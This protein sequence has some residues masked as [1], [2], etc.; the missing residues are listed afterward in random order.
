MVLNCQEKGTQ[1]L[2]DIVLQ[3]CVYIILQV[4]ARENAVA[5]QK[6]SIHHTTADS[7]EKYALPNKP[8]AAPKIQGVNIFSYIAS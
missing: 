5:A 2:S 3:M 7:G 4:I 6:V 8:A 1:E